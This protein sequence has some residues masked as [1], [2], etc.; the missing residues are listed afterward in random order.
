MLIADLFKDPRLAEK[1]RQNG[2]VTVPLLNKQQVAAV[3]TLHDRLEKE[4]SLEHGF[5]A[6]VWSENKNYRTGVQQV[7]INALSPAIAAYLTNVKPVLGA[8]QVKQAGPATQLQAHQD[9]SF[10]DEPE[11]DTVLVWCPLVDVDRHN[12]NLQ[13]VPGSQHLKNYVRGRF[14]DAP[15]RALDNAV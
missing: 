12:G 14:F 11:N 13:V 15:F 5:Y 4:A 8:F 6:S 9:W 1:Y 10:V 2:F 3:T 7:S